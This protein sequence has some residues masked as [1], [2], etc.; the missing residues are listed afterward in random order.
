MSL[1]QKKR[2]FPQYQELGTDVYDVDNKIFRDNSKFVTACANNNTNMI[3]TRAPQLGKTTLLSLAELLL[4]NTK[5]APTGQQ[6]KADQS[7]W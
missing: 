4:N 5:T 1:L 3:F 7:S 2:K 6:L